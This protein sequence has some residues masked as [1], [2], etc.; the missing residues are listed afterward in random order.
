MTKNKIY[1]IG[2]LAVLLSTA[3]VIMQA[4]SVT[5]AKPIAFPNTY[6]RETNTNVAPGGT[7]TLFADCFLGDRALSGG[8]VQDDVHDLQIVVS[9]VSTNINPTSYIVKAVNTSTTTSRT[10]VASVLCADLT[11]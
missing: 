11:P 9:G 10:L 3:I 6:E 2:A 4:Q 1:A 7:Q 8:F 5:A